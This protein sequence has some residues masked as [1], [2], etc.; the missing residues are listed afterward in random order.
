ALDGGHHRPAMTSVA[1]RRL[2]DR[3]ARPELPGPL[4]LFD[5]GQPDPVLYAAARVELLELGEDGRLDPAG[6][7]V[8]AHQRSVP[9]EVENT[10]RDLHR[11]PSICLTA[12]CS[13]PHQ[14]KKTTSTATARVAFPMVMCNVQP[15]GW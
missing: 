6:D 9:D 3:P 4:R 5:H 10:F 11:T 1:A 2:D 7:L 14:R 8:Q 12:P 15:T 13:A